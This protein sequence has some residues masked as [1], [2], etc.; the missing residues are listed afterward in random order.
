MKPFNESQKLIEV[1]LNNLIKTNIKNIIFDTKPGQGTIHCIKTWAKENGFIPLEFD[2]QRM[3]NYLFAPY[4]IMPWMNSEEK[5]LPIWFSNI[6]ENPNSK[7][8][9]IV[10]D[11]LKAEKKLYD[12]FSIMF[13]NN[14]VGSVAI[15]DN[16]I[17]VLTNTI[18]NGD[19]LYRSLVAR[20]YYIKLPTVSEISN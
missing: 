1:S 17:F 9:L 5:Y 10:D 13:H 11:I 4:P 6:I 18:D 19:E 15:P 14:K 7:Y 2:T 8:L 16:C 3:D 12:D 20:C